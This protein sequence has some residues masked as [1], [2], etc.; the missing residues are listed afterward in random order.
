MQNLEVFDFQLIEAQGGS[1]RVLFHIKI[2]IK[3]M[4]KRLTN[5]LKSLPRFISYKKIQTFF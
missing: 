2:L 3:L 1:I 5:K 4:Q